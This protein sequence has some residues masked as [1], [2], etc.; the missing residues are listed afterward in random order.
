MPRP[1]ACPGLVIDRHGD[2]VVVQSGTAGNDTLMDAILD[3][4]DS[5][6]KP[7]T[8]VVKSDGPARALEGLEA[9][10]RVVTG[11]LD[12]PIAVTENGLTFF[13]DPLEGQKTGW[14]Y[15]QRWNR[16]R[17]ATLA[18][19]AGVLDVYSHTGGFG[20]GAAAAGASS[21]I[22][23]DKSDKALDFARKAAEANNVTS[24]CGFERAEAFQYLE[25]LGDQKQRFDIVCVDPPAFAKSKKDVGAALKGYRKLARLASRVV[26]K[27]GFLFAASCSHNV[28][29]ERFPGRDH[30]GLPPKRTHGPHTGHRRA[31]GPDHP[32]PS[33]AARNSVSEI[34][35]DAVGL[36]RGRRRPLQHVIPAERHR[37]CRAKDPAINCFSLI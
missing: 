5:V 8:V 21:V 14:F 34:G 16:A 18:R 19:G 29:E 1:T 33:P 11:T 25:K 6:L 20:I 23:V 37:H 15:D 13:A 24:V 22:C 3:A 7:K 31:A 35:V 9:D 4:V 26:A 17:I 32:R 12:G 2:V 36:R 28:L 27:G 10:S 30:P